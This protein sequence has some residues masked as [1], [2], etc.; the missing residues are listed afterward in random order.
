MHAAQVSRGNAIIAELLRLAE[1][2]PPVFLQDHPK[3]VRPIPPP[4]TPTPSRALPPPSAARAAPASPCHTVALAAR[5]AVRQRMGAQSKYHHIV[6]DFAYF[7]SAEYYDNVIDKNPELQDTD[8]EVRLRLRRRRRPPPPRAAH[9]ALQFK[10]NHMEILSRFY[11]AFESVLKYVRDLNRILEDLDEGVFIQQ[12]M[13]SAMQD[14]AGRQ[15]MAESIFLY[16][17]MLLLADLKLPGRVRERMLVSFNRYCSKEAEQA[18]IDDVVKLLRSTGYT[19]GGR[20][21]KY[22]EDYFAREAVPAPFVRMLISRMRSD[23]IY[24]QCS[25]YPDPEHRSTAL[26]T[27]GSMLY[28]ML[29]FA[30]EILHGEQ[31]QMREIV[32]KHFPD[33]WVISVYMGEPV[34]LIDAWEPYRAARTALNNTLDPANVTRQVQKHVAKCPA[35]NTEL[36]GLL[37]EGVLTRDYVLDSVKKLVHTMREANVTLRW[38]MMHSHDDSSWSPGKRS[39]AVRDMV[40]GGGFDKRPRSAGL[41]SPHGTCCC[42]G[43]TGG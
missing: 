41:S 23:D 16:G 30:P 17:V 39:R 9:A 5:A 12:T 32:D 35:L 34:D 1:F 24:N 15:L 4:A 26:A 18:N 36:V 3:T 11:K 38:L 6:L 29:Y 27:Q 28:V 33:N 7:R 20:P 21:A 8:E 25:E 40:L 10:E 37:K 22:P 43:I 42:C 14:E 13:E 2:V 31:A 19:R